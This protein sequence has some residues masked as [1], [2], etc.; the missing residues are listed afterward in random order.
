MRR[1]NDNLEVNSA[2]TGI[3]TGRSLHG[4]LKAAACFV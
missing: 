1:N 4:L 2:K 3:L